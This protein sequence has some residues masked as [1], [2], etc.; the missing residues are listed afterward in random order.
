MDSETYNEMMD[1]MYDDEY[2]SSPD[3][4][5]PIPN[6]HKKN[7]SLDLSSLCNDIRASFASGFKD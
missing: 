7:E 5:R 6:Y 1:W 3:V 4:L 2:S